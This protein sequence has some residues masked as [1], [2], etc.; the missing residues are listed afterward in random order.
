MGS[1]TWK[2]SSTLPRMAGGG[3]T[4]GTLRE[5]KKGIAQFY[6]LYIFIYKTL[7]VH[8]LLPQ[9]LITEQTSLTLEVSH[10]SRSTCA[11]VRSRLHKYCVDKSIWS[12]WSDLKCHLGK[13]STIFKYNFVAGSSTGMFAPS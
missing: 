1:S 2:G 8:V 10:G 11:K 6:C 7:H 9:S 12:E 3:R 5:R 13:S 4:T